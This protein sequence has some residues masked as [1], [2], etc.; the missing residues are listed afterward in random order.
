MLKTFENAADLSR[1]E[2]GE[3]AHGLAHLDGLRADKLTLQRRLAILQQHVVW[4]PER[5]LGGTMFP[6]AQPLGQEDKREEPDQHA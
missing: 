4:R 5:G 2:D 3:M 1:L 6:P